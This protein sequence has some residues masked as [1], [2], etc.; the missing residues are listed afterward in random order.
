MSDH[1]DML[2]KYFVQAQEQ[3]S[4]L[5]RDDAR[6]VLM[7]AGSASP[8]N[9]TRT[10]TRSVYAT[11]AISA[12]VIAI[13]LMLSSDNDVKTTAVDMESIESIAQTTS[14]AHSAES[15]PEHNNRSGI[16]D[17]SRMSAT[18]LGGEE[19]Q[20]GNSIS[21]D[22]TAA[23]G[24]SS[25]IEVTLS[26]TTRELADQVRRSSGFHYAADFA[27]IAL[28]EE[29]PELDY[30]VAGT[31]L[32]PL[33]ETHL[34]PEK[35]VIS[36]LQTLSI[37][38]YD[39]YNPMISPDGRTLYFIS[40]REHGFGGHDFW[41]ATKEHRDDLE[42]SQPRNLGSGIN[43]P[44]DE[45]AGSISGDGQ[46]MYFTGCDRA[47]GLGD[48]DI[49]EAQLGD[50][51][52]V[53]V[54]NVREINSKYWDV[55][56]TVSADGRAIY[57]ISNRPGAMGSHD[58]ADIYVSYKKADGTWSIPENLGSPVNTSKREDS[59]FIAPGGN[60]LYFSSAGHKGMGK[61]DF[62]VSYKEPNGQWGTPENLGPAF[63]SPNDERFI[64]LP[65]AEDIVYFASSDGKKGLDLFMGRRDARSSSV[66]INGKILQQETGER[67]NARLLFVDG[68]TG[69]VLAGTSTNEET[70]EFSFVIGQHTQH[71]TI[72]VYGITD[73]SQEFRAQISVPPATSYL[74]YQCDMTLQQTQRSLTELTAGWSPG[75]TIKTE[76][77]PNHVTLEVPA[78]SSDTELLI[79]DAWGH[80]LF[81]KKISKGNSK[82]TIDFTGMPQG[83][84]LARIGE[85]TGIIEVNRKAKKS[86]KG[87]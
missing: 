50:E 24:S 61:L 25:S 41:I 70:G 15:N 83:L 74:V 20:A 30:I 66:V 18:P 80:K 51:G 9:R 55:Q 82:E 32:M 48:C 38:Q 45:G 1:E 49:Y 57:F 52:W 42:F 75:L 27:E 7:K 71:R 13:F 67:L 39:D 72:N 36:K 3:P 8:K 87:S 84:Y 56:P 73:E 23:R 77:D 2:R 59:P 43:T 69:E 11:A 28:P 33:A 63:N 35:V 10:G 22:L 62:F 4:L 17:M 40:T 53:Q 19:L 5:S 78:T 81:E 76:A 54:R 14:P 46:V 60:A 68:I 86:Q 58:D 47:D 31:S 6:E 64:T 79:L 21:K 37:P 44:G 29:T 26:A 12:A 65:A 85:K 16:Q 34:L